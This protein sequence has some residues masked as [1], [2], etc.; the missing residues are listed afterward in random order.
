M[1]SADARALPLDDTVT[2]GLLDSFELALK[3]AVAEAV[4]EGAADPVVR[5]ELL[6]QSDSRADEVEAGE[7]LSW[8]LGVE[9]A[10]ALA[11]EGGD[12]EEA[13]LLDSRALTLG[14]PDVVSI[15]VADGVTLV[16]L[17]RDGAVEDVLSTDSVTAAVDDSDGCPVVDGRAVA[18]CTSGDAETSGV[19]VPNVALSR[20]LEDARALAVALGDDDPAARVSDTT[21]VCDDDRVRIGEADDDTD[22]VTVREKGAER[23]AVLD[24]ERSADTECVP[25]LHVLAVAKGDALPV[26]EPV[27]DAWGLAVEITVSD[28][29]EELL[30]DGS[31]ETVAE[32]DDVATNELDDDAVARPDK[33]EDKDAVAEMETVVDA[34]AERDSNV[35]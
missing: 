19:E 4:P 18:L 6:A 2:D 15:P 1:S 9:T 3:L 11:P 8:T 23:E 35:L 13:A 10:L 7:L 16:Q 24:E 22:G 21:V 33:V 26:L 28:G 12:G 31:G 30:R 27:G 17:E 25:E 34:G 14:A 20:L 5:T 29:D 32:A